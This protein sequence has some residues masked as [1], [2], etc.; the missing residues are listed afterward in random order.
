MG[1]NGVERGSFAGCESQKVESKVPKA[2][3]EGDKWNHIISHSLF[4]TEKK[5]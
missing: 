4:N 5:R 1:R 2:V 3:V